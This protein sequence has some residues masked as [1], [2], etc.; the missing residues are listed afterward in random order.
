M[1]YKIGSL[2][3]VKKYIVFFGYEDN[4][5]N[6]AQ[7]DDSL[8]IEKLNKFIELK[9]WKWKKEASASYID[10][11]TG[12]E[13]MLCGLGKKD[14]LTKVILRQAMAKLTAAIAKVKAEDIYVVIPEFEDK[15]LK[16]AYIEALIDGLES[17]EYDFIKYKEK[18]K[19]DKEDEK[20]DKNVNLLNWDLCEHFLNECVYVAKAKSITKNLVNEP[21]NVMTPQK[22]A[23]TTKALGEEFGFKVDVYDENYI[24]EK[25]MESYWSV[26]MG[27][28]LMPRL[29]VCKYMGNPDNKEDIIALVGKGLTYDSGGYA[30]K[31]ASG[32]ATMKSDM[33]GSAA[34]IGAIT[35][36]ARMK[37][38]VNVVCVVAACE[39]MISGRA[40]RNGD[41]IG[42]MAGKHI[43]V[44]NT[45]AEGRLTLIDAVTYA[46]REMKATKVVDIATLTGAALVALGSTRT[47]VVSNNDEFFAELED[48]SEQANEKI[49]RLPHDKEYKDLLKSD[50][51]D[52]KNIG[53]RYAGTITAGLFIGE[54]VEEK[55][56]LHLDIAGTS[57]NDK[58]GSTGHGA[59]LLYHLVKNTEK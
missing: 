1:N 16:V 25:K 59:K 57:W 48:A 28:D 7:Y 31:T 46:V 21:A 27:S 42:S 36:I 12:Q 22:L 15:E 34:V 40:Y 8:S 54:F 6:L 2:N 9:E 38:K 51:A 37:L 32:M 35:A 33:G 41:I 44:L 24:Q 11:E 58:K 10:V 26:A 13:V 50:I 20:K 55:P 19:D 53:G 30:I 43:E 18:K 45:D 56:W 39:N 5:A 52:L 49:W 29:I 23:D 47:A 17:V 3:D 14:K 4:S